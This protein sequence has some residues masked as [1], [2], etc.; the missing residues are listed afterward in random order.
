MTWQKM[1]CFTGIDLHDSFV[2]S[3]SIENNSIVFVLEVSIWPE[4]PHYDAP[5][6]N[7]YT[8]YR[9]GALSFIGVSNVHGLRDCKE[10]TPTQDSDG[11]KD[12][13][14]IDYLSQILNGYELH[15]EFGNVVIVGGE[16]NF[17]IYA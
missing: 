5:K 7:E 10:L 16:L 6:K 13:G 11:S 17:E 3:W 4:S 14:N 12:Y 8:C 1:E 2:L 15:G 9:K